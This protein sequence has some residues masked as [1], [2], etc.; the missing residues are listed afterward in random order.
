[1]D[2]A[3]AIR[4]MASEQYL[5][6][7]LAPKV[8]DDFEEHLFNCSE[9]AMDL[10]STAAFVQQVK[11]V[12]PELE[13]QEI[14][15]TAVP[16][17]Q[18]R[19]F[20]WMPA[21]SMAAIAALLI[22]IA[23]QNFISNPRLQ[24]QLAQAN[25]PRVLASASL[26]SARDTNIPQITARPNTPALV[27]LDIPA[28][29]IYSSYI[30]RLYGPGGKLAWSLPIDGETAKDT[31][32]IQIPPSQA[33]SGLYKLVLYGVDTNPEKENEIRQYKFQLKYEN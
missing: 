29:R 27:F 26:V 30:A 3:E 16:R 18:K 22:V 2:H 33:G 14:T 11:V 31:V 21:F 28:E 12:L 7:E 17:R 19:R 10:R 24:N 9:C 23:Y 15:A 13:S 6:N 25:V 8:R 4:L 20:A 1:M 5:L 32:S